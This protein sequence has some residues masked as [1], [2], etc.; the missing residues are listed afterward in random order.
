MTDRLKLE[1]AIAAA[2]L[3]FGVLVLPFAIYVVGVQVVGPYAEGEGVLD[4]A[5]DVWTALGRGQ[6]A[7]WLLVLAPY[8]VVQ[9]ARLTRLIWRSRPV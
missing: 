9:L 2:L 8:L 7:A 4:L 1:A 5:A 6:L 3:S